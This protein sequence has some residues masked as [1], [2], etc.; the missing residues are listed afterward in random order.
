MN[1]QE[2][3]NL[4]WEETQKSTLGKVGK[5]FERL[6]VDSGDGRERDYF[7]EIYWGP[8]YK[9]LACCVKVK[10]A[11]YVL[12]LGADRGVG[13]I[14]LQSELVGSGKVYSVDIDPTSWKYVPANL[15]TV[16]K[17]IGDSIDQETIKK[18]PLSQID[19]CLID[20]N[21]DADH[22]KKEIE[23]YTPHFKKGT[24]LVFDDINSYWPT[25]DNSALDKIEDPNN[26]HYN[27]G[28]GVA[29]V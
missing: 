12:E 23:L 21:H 22:V 8:F 7:K 17:V 9:F 29:I 11:K 27:V 18:I 24:I 13:S 4:A 16:K 1:A 15:K 14:F 10:K 6:S 19:L 2:F 5:Y 20:S 28:L 3:Y 26:I 25:W